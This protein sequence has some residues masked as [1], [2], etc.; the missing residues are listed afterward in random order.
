MLCLTTLSVSAT[1]VCP[2]LWLAAVER[3]VRLLYVLQDCTIYRNTVKKHI[4]V[5]VLIK[6][7]QAS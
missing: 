4:F 6:L 5:S 7:T 3:H 2:V 1:F